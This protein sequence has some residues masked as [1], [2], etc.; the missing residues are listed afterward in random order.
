MSSASP[1]SSQ[2]K[3]TVSMEQQQ[4]QS[5]S[6]SIPSQ[7]DSP[8][9]WLPG[10]KD[11][12][13]FQCGLCS[14]TF[15]INVELVSHV[16]RHSLTKPYQCGYCKVSYDDNPQLI[17]HVRTHTMMVI[18]APTSTADVTG[19]Q[20][21][22]TCQQDASK[23]PLVAAA[24]HLP[25]DSGAVV[26]TGTDHT[27]LDNLSTDGIKAGKVSLLRKMVEAEVPVSSGG[28]RTA[29]TLP[30][31]SDDSLTKKAQTTSLQT[32]AVVENTKHCQQEV[33]SEVVSDEDTD[34]QEEV[35]VALDVKTENDVENCSAKKQAELTQVVCSNLASDSGGK[36]GSQNSTLK[37]FACDICGARFKVARYISDH[38]RHVHQK[39]RPKS[40]KKCGLSE[41]EKK[42]KEADRPFYCDL[43]G[44]RFRLARYVTDHKRIVHEKKRTPKNK[45]DECETDICDT[46]RPFK[47]DMCGAGYTAARYL[48]CHKRRKHKAEIPTRKQEQ[49]A[50]DDEGYGPFPCKHCGALFKYSRYVRD[51]ERIVHNIW[52]EKPRP[53]QAS[54]RLCTTCGTFF[55]SKNDVYRHFCQ[56]KECHICGRKLKTKMTYEKHMKIHSE[57]PNTCTCEVCGQSFGRMATLRHHQN[58]RHFKS[59]PFKCNICQKSFS[60]RPGLSQHKI[61]HFGVKKHTCVHCGMKF[62][63]AHSLQRHALTHTDLRLYP[64]KMC[65]NTYRSSTSLMYHTKHTH[66]YCRSSNSP[67]L[68]FNEKDE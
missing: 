16:H 49:A 51:H 65:S 26:S 40:K 41:E 27:M 47:C 11:Q 39:L 62:Y 7:G 54:P 42:Q 6:S 33:K 4:G 43:C 29:G 56:P 23:H 35:E 5:P 37:P 2:V 31:L 59:K 28:A 44:A 66:Q 20:L 21:I 36:Q 13:P 24:Q 10:Q 53:K 17:V 45:K 34:A 25:Q 60:S 30:P 8:F 48:T 64:C 32:D 50:G 12:K 58:A 68:G 3:E 14:V 57:N 15:D 55:K 46:D 22:Q 63:F 18:R 61:R 19:V 9:S 52:V 67:A 38:K 1:E